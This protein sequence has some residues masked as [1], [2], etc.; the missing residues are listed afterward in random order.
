MPYGLSVVA[1]RLPGF[2]SPDFAAGVIL[3]DVLGSRRGN[4]YALVPRGEALFTDFDA[5]GFPKGGFGFATA[6]FT[7]GADGA[8]LVRAVRNVISGYVKD[9]IP[10]DLV[11]AAKRH[12]VGD[13]EFRKNAIPGLANVWSQALAVEGRTSPDDDVE[14]IKKVTAE[15]V[16]RVAREY[17]RNERA[18]TA[19]LTPRL[20]GKPV[21][22]KG[23]GGGESFSPRQATAVELPP[24]ARGTLSLPAIIPSNVKPIDLKLTNGILA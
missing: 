8:V 18:V 22:S 2:D 11:E 14:A 21:A 6:G 23:F 16:N 3:A 5:E 13:A 7:Q 1:Y 20:S 12:E 4:L 24:W 9:G 17:L 10:A 15:D 19:V